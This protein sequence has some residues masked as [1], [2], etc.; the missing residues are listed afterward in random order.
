MNTYT[1]GNRIAHLLVIAFVSLT[2]SAC[3][4][5]RNTQVEFGWQIAQ[6]NCITCHAIGRTGDS[7]LDEAPPFRRLHERYKIDDLAEAFAE[8]IVVGHK[9]MPPFAFEP[10]QIDALLA[11]LKSLSSREQR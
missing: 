9:E 10:R 2:C 7:P 4:R 1:F 5:T 3:G 8:G 6:T 11:Y